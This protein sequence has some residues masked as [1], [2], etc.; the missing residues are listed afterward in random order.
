MYAK[1]HMRLILAVAAAALNR[2]H[3]RFRQSSTALLA[4]KTAG[5][6]LQ[7]TV[8]AAHADAVDPG[9]PLQVKRFDR[10]GEPDPREDPSLCE[11]TPKF[12]E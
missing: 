5:A 10:L 3:W 9:T 8:W 6:V 11:L 4:E 12:T 7:A 2:R 1:A